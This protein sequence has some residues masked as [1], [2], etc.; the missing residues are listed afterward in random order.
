MS[1]IIDLCNMFGNVHLSFSNI[2][3]VLSCSD[4]ERD[5][6]SRLYLNRN[7]DLSSLRFQFSQVNLLMIDLDVFSHTADVLFQ[8]IQGSLN[9]FS[10]PLI[11][12][13]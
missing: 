3:N 11:V 6:D 2:T 10:R 8:L 9:S 12:G 7:C 13:L 4:I 5:S 1:C